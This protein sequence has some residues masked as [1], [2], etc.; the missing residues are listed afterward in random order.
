SAGGAA[1]VGAIGGQ[2]AQSVADGE[3]AGGGAVGGRR[4]R[5]RHPGVPASAAPHD[6]ITPRE[7]VSAVALIAITEPAD[8]RGWSIRGHNPLAFGSST[9]RMLR[10]CAASSSLDERSQPGGSTHGKDQ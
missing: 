7:H 2:Q 5:A 3:S 4:D 10:N 9:R 8:A 6:R 1:P